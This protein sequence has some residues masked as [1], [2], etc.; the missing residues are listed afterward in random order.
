MGIEERARV[1][2][3]LILGYIREPVDDHLMKKLIRLRQALKKHADIDFV[4]Y[5]PGGVH[6]AK[7]IQETM[8]MS[9]ER[10]LD[11]GWGKV[12]MPVGGEFR[13]GPRETGRG[14]TI[15]PMIH[16]TERTC[17]SRPTALVSAMFMLMMMAGVQ[18]VFRCNGC[19]ELFF[20]KDYRK[21]TCSGR[22]RV[23]ASQAKKTEEQREEQKKRRSAA[24]HQK[25][26]REIY[27]RDDS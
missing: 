6:Y 3:E 22:C 16:D 9:L 21:K 24:Y 23:K 25:R 2:L 13:L 26:R 19:R 15:L 7:H 12:P 4:P 18:R 1:G 27:G 5:L 14:F 20:A 17:K 10:I 11:S 8:R